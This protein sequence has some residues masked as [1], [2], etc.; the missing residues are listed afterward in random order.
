VIKTQLIN[1]MPTGA[2]LIKQVK[3]GTAVGLTKLAKAAQREVVTSI[4]S[5]FTTRGRWFEQSN[6]MGIKI[7]PAKPNKLYSEVKTL[8]DWLESHE[9]GGTKTPKGRSRLSVPLWG[10]R[11]K[12]SRRVLSKSLRPQALLAAGKAFMLKTPFGEIIATTRGRGSNS[13]IVPLYGLE[14]SV[15]IRKRSTFYE[16]IRR[17]LA[18]NGTHI[19]ERE[20]INALR[21]AKKR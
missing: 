5:T 9:R 21:T 10:A 4:T 20:V 18:K 8:A 14:R 7:T 6:R 19:L 15:K 16:P 17:V 2:E 1:N 13:R 12:G 3:F 11:P